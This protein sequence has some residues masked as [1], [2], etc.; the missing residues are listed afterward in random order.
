M[1]LEII[2]LELGVPARFC[3]I[4]RL[5]YKLRPVLDR[6]GEVADVNNV[7]RFAEGPR[8]LAVV[9]FEF[10]I[11]GN[12]TCEVRRFW[13]LEWGEWTDQPGCVGLRSVPMISTSG[14]SSPTSL[15]NPTVSSQEKTKDGTHQARSPISQSQFRC[16]TPCWDCST[17]IG[18]VSGRGGCGIFDGSSQGGRVRPAKE[19]RLQSWASASSKLVLHRSA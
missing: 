11:G 5:R 8:L 13:R 18:E 7:K 6:G 4:E 15:I 9:D 3:G 17:G 10:D 1:I 2:I 16:P 12:P 19:L 14:C